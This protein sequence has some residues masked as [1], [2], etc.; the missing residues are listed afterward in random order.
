MHFETAGSLWGGRRVWV[1]AR[2]P[3]YVEFGGKIRARPTSTSPT[4][5][6]DRWPSPPAVT[7][8]RI[9]C[10][11]TLDLNPPSGWADQVA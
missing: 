1:L 9:V 4:A 11:N 8:I 3:E 10:A 2:L 7:P 6:T 5:T